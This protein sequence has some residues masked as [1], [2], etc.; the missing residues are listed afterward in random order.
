MSTQGPVRI[1]D[2]DVPPGEHPETGSCVRMERPEL[3]L[4]RV[5]LDPPHRKATVLDYP[6]L[7][8]LELAVE[9]L[10]QDVALRGVVITGREPL[11]F[12]FGADVDAI[13]SLTDRKEVETLSLAVHALFNPRSLL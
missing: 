13:E 2:L 9:Q 6:L 5:V 8:D 1:Q 3:G 4:A 10:E 7:R 12:A 11:H